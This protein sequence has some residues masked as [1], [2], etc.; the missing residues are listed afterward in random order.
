MTIQEI[1]TKAKEIKEWQH[2]VESA[3]ETITALQG[4]LKTAMTDANTDMLI[5]GPFRLTYKT[6][7]T[8]RVDTV[9]LKR[10]LPAIVERFIRTTTTRRFT[11]A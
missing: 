2:L 4:E 11:I 9:A 3:N 5:A 10:E 1:E 8:S 7:E 6:V